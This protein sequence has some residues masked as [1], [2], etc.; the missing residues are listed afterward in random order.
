MSSL[1]RVLQRGEPL[2][3]AAH[4]LHRLVDRQRG[5]REPDDL[6]GV[7]DGDVLDVVGAVDELDVLGCLAGRAD[8]L[9]VSLVADE[10]DVVVAVGEPHGL[11]VHL[12]DQRAGRVDG[13]QRQRPR[14]LVDDRG[15]TV[16]REDDGRALGHLVGLVDEDRA[17]PLQCRHDVLV[18]HDLLAHVDGCAVQVERL[19]DR[20]DGPVDA[21]AVAAGCREEHALRGVSHAVHRRSPGRP[22]RIA[23]GGVDALRTPAGRS[24][25]RPRSQPPAPGRRSRRPSAG[26]PT[27]SSRRSTT[28]AGTVPSARPATVAWSRSSTGLGRRTWG[29]PTS[30]PRTCRSSRAGACA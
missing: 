5:L 9:L 27:S 15:D 14:L 25:A 6:V 19:L 24:A 20:H 12:G 28:C 3:K 30:A 16:R 2:A 18:V 8:D 26:H 10:E 1:G 21:R 17:A 13:A 11:A 22:P 29:G 23:G 4:G 7:A